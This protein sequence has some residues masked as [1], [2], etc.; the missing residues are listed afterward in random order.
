ML[1]DPYMSTKTTSVAA[2]GLAVLVVEGAKFERRSLCRL[3]RAAGA[4]HV[5]E[6]TD[7]EAARRVL[8]Q[9]RRPRWL[10]LADPE[11]IDDPE[12]H[13]LAA[14]ASQHDI[15]ASLLLTAQRPPAADALRDKARRCGLPLLAALRKPVSAEEAGMLLRRLAAAPV[16]EPR[17]PVI[18]KEELNECLRAGRVRARFQ[19]KLELDSGRPVACE[20]SSY[21][22]HARY[23]DVPVAGLAPAL[24]QLGAHRVMTASV[25]REAASLVRALR[26]KALDARVSVNLVADVLSEPGDAAALDS[27]VRT[28]G[29]SPGDLAL[30]IDLSRRSQEPSYLADNLA[31]L[32]LRGYALALD[33]PATMPQDDPAHAHFTEVKLRWPG[34]DSPAPQR[35]DLRAVLDRARKQG[36]SACALGVR[37]ADDL[38]QARRAGF[39]L[40]QGE[41]FAGF[42]PA[43]DIVA[44]M[45]REE[46]SRSFAA[47]DQRLDLAG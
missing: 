21:L 43:I 23:G 6:A 7:L 41:L 8:T 20:A 13:A 37:N 10:L 3:M 33:E 22:D 1:I 34:P 2:D 27:Y 9:R 45:E 32:K 15:V 4:E 30:E 29:V 17:L 5:A 18:S 16:A 14:L 26:A 38:Q 35:D 36:M 40:G 42:M 47:T 39:E 25:M 31:R 28:L 19:P 12:L 24:A 11:R 46:R 44:W